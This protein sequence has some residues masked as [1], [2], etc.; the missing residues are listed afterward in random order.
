[1]HV[2]KYIINII[3]FNCTE[4]IDSALTDTEPSR[5]THL[6]VEGHELLLVPEL[7]ALG[8]R[9]RPIASGQTLGQ[10]D[11]LPLQGDLT[12]LKVTAFLY[13]CGARN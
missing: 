1:M 3:I 6:T 7:V 12:R 5:R 4:H 8:G 2:V 9:Q 13:E 11:H 10:T